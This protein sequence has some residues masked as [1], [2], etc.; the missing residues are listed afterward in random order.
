MKIKKMSKNSQNRN[1]IRIQ[2]I[3]KPSPGANFRLFKALSMLIDE[4]DIRDYSQRIPDTLVV[5]TF[6]STAS[7][8]VIRAGATSG[9]P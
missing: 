8:E 1:N 3:Y 9:P 5:A 2:L 6:A 7:L 4:K